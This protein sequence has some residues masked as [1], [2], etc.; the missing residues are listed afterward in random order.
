MPWLKIPF[1]LDLCKQKCTKRLS[2]RLSQL[3]M[4]FEN[5]KGSHL[6]ALPISQCLLGL[7]GGG[8]GI[9]TH[10]RLSPTSVFKTGA[11]NHSATPPTKDGVLSFKDV[12]KG[13]SELFSKNNSWQYLTLWYIGNIF[14]N[15]LQNREP[16]LFSKFIWCGDNLCNNLLVHFC[17]QRSNLKGIF[18]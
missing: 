7:C 18:N 15:I 5:K 10:G 3:Q 8:G 9:R 11:F 17:L 1:K 12:I 13:L 2:Q 16:F 14:G 4:H 6:R